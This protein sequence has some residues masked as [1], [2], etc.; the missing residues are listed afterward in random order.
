L[1]KYGLVILGAH[2]GVHILKDLKKNREKNI[3][4]KKN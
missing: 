2:F 3:L 1:A 4:A